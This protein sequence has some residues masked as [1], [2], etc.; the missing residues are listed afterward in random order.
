[1]SLLLILF[2]FAGI[3]T[4]A[5]L[6]IF[7]FSFIRLKK[8]KTTTY[9]ALAAVTGTY[10]IILTVFFLWRVTDITRY[11]KAIPNNDGTLIFEG[12]RYIADNFDE[13]PYGKN[14]KKVATVEYSTDSK[15]IDLINSIFFPSRLYSESDDLEKRVL[16]ERGLMLEVKYRKID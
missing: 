6:G 13:F 9:K 2:L 11:P 15:A 1:M 16:W 8:S 3:F 10:L 5:V 14:I 7:L 4:I 12:N